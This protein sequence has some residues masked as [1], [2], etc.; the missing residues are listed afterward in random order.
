MGAIT[1]MS[2]LTVLV[3]PSGAGK[4]TALE[5]LLL[6]AGGTPGS[7]IARVVIRRV[8]TK[9]AARWLFWRGGRTDDPTIRIH[10][11][12]DGEP[13]RAITLRLAS[14]VDRDLEEKL[15]V[16]RAR[17]PFA[18]IN[19][20]LAWGEREREV[21]AR[22]ALSYDNLYAFEQR[23]VSIDQRGELPPGRVRLVDPR[24]G[25]MHA[26]LWKSYMEAFEGGR[27]GEVEALVREVIPDLDR[28]VPLS[29]DDGQSLVHLGYK[30]HS[31]PVALAGDGI[32][33]LVQVSLAVAQSAGSTV[34]LEEPESAQHPRA[35]Y[36]TARAISAAVKRGVQVILSTHSLELIDWLLAGMEGHLEKMS[37][38]QMACR[39]GALVVARF[40]GTDVDAARDVI[41]EDFR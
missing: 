23:A 20:D 27:A 8:E 1:G 11:G 17:A 26:P 32:Q 36:W 29:D 15:T 37:L 39:D 7:A 40:A 4:S 33:T 13:P 9:G 6:G 34:L 25:G 31:V 10:V 21:R 30:D 38:H 5:A 41:G 3:G 24:P 14:E 16:T 18:Q 19:A 35:A 2:P 28:I 22:T 12:L